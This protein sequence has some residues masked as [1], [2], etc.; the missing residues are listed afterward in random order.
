M[1]SAAIRCA[2]KEKSK[3]SPETGHIHRKIPSRG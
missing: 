3:P 2:V 1:K